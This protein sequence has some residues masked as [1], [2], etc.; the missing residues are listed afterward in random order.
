MD[1]GGTLEDLKSKQN[2]YDEAWRKFVGT[3]EE[4]VECLEVLGYDEELKN[5]RNSYEEHVVRKLTFDTNI[6]SWKSEAM[7]RVGLAT[8]LS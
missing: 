6:E 2:S 1:A 3:H 8:P 5:A 4:Y 7:K